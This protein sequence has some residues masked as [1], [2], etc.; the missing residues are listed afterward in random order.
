MSIVD[1]ISSIN[2]FEEKY[3]AAADDYSLA[4][5]FWNI[6]NPNPHEMLN[7]GLYHHLRK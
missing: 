1:I 7:K 6:Y 3:K 2:E 4:T 5:K